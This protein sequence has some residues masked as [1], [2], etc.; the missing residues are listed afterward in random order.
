[1]MMMKK[2]TLLGLW[3][4]KTKLDVFISYKKLSFTYSIPRICLKQLNSLCI[5]FSLTIFIGS[6][7]LSAE[8]VGCIRQWIWMFHFHYFKL[9][10][11]HSF[12]PSTLKNCMLSSLSDSVS[13]ALLSQWIDMAVYWPQPENPGK[14]IWKV[15]MNWKFNLSKN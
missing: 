3:N 2:V 11:F 13:P 10:M 12:K 7:L 15:I 4:S 5:F 14:I 8:A 1:M 6:H 9:K